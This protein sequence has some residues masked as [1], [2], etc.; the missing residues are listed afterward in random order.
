M[1]LT[2]IIEMFNS[3]GLW[4]FDK[5]GGLQA[6]DNF[7]TYYDQLVVE[8]PNLSGFIDCLG[9]LLSTFLPIPII[10]L[11]IALNVSAWSLSL[12]FAILWRVKSLVPTMGADEAVNLPLQVLRT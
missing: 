4:L 6:I 5:L 11:C 3:F 10:L 12:F 2:Q 7:G 8:H 1:F 9:S